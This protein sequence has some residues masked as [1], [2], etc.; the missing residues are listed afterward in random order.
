M[1]L[2]ILRPRN[3]NH[4]RWR[5]VY[6]TLRCVVCSAE[7]EGAARTIAT[8]HHGDEG[9]DAWMNDDLVSCEELT[10]GNVQTVHCADFIEA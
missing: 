5:N 9:E 2:W 8:I 3:T 7:T 1:K 10:A 4:P 6:D